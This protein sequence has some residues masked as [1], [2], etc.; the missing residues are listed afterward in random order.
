VWPN[1]KGICSKRFFS[2][3]LA[4]ITAKYKKLI[5]AQIA[6]NDVVDNI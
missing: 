1:W 5:E 3:N 6:L 2:G 4:K